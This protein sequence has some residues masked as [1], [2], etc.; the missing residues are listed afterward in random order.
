[1]HVTSAEAPRLSS[2]QSVSGRLPSCAQR[3]TQQTSKQSRTMRLAASYRQHHRV[4]G[5]Y[6]RMQYSPQSCTA[7]RHATCDMRRHAHL[8][9]LIS[10]HST[11]VPPSL[12]RSTPLRPVVSPPASEHRHCS[13]TDIIRFSPTGIGGDTRVD[14]IS[15]GLH[16]SLAPRQN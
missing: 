2:R 9:H 11:R 8:A 15:V 6:C 3:Q 10:S 7:P 13:S 12:H 14:L 1:M 16:A 5:H 4:S